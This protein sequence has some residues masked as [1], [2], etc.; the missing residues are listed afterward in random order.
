MK[1]FRW[2]RPEPE[3]RPGP[4]STPT[5]DP[6]A[7]PAKQPSSDTE[8]LA[9]RYG[10]ERRRMEILFTNLA[11]AEDETKLTRAQQALIFLKSNR[12]KEA[13]TV[14]CSTVDTPALPTATD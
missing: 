7:E 13:E 12:L 10:A 6:K 2:R 1:F 11:E 14:Q 9:E 8:L 3:S 4:E 5:P